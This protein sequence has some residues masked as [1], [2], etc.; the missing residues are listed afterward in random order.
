MQGTNLY[1]S[2][3]SQRSL[4]LAWELLFLALWH[5]R[6]KNGQKRAK[7]G[8]NLQKQATMGKNGQ[9]CEQKRAQKRGQKGAEAGKNG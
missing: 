1:P 7:M 9:N 6:S 5:K 3:P 8:K 2:W 4:F